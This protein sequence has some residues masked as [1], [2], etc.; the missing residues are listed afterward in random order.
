MKTDEGKEVFRQRKKIIEHPLGTTKAVWGYR[1]FLCRTQERVTGEESLEL[2][3][4][5]QKCDDNIF[6]G[7]HEEI[8]ATMV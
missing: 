3:A 2:L 5:N 8:V 4:Y 7:N 6:K 1:Q